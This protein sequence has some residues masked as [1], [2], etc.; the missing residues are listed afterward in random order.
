MNPFLAEISQQAKTLRQLT[1]YYCIGEGTALLLSVPKPNLPI[2]T[3]MGASYHAAW[4]MGH[5]LQNSGLPALV[6]EASDLLSYGAALLRNSNHILYI[7][8]SGAS[9]EVEPIIELMPD[10]ATLVAVTNNPQ[11]LLGQRAD[12]ILPLQV[13]S[14]ST[15]ATMTYSN[16]LAL[17]WLLFRHWNGTIGHHDGGLL[18]HVADRVEKLVTKGQKTSLLF[19]EALAKGNALVFVGHGPHAATARHSAMILGEWAKTIAASFG[20]GAFRHGFIE[21]VRPGTS[22]VVFTPP[23]NTFS[24][25]Y[26]LAQE[27]ERYGASVITITNGYA[28]SL[29]DEI[30]DG[31]AIDEFLSPILD[32]IPVQFLTNLLARE[33]N[34]EN[35]FRY[36]GKVVNKL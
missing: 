1:E 22:V 5:T 27:L 2:I 7:S 13:D 24:S 12:I 33:R 31:D 14:E 35:K 26:S 9:A 18:M 6:L 29:A 21:F 32:I 25:A 11:S 28:H 4:A 8:Q 3:G 30:E 17:L 36:I 16:S 23:G 20:I 10:Q 34:S 15:V 19:Y